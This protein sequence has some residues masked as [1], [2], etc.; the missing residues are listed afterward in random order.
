[1]MTLDGMKDDRPRFGPFHCERE[2]ERERRA[3]DRQLG[4]YI[5]G[6]DARGDWFNNNSGDGRVARPT[7]GE[8]M[9]GMKSS[10]GVAFESIAKPLASEAKDVQSNRSTSRWSDYVLGVAG[11]S[12]L[13]SFGDSLIRPP[14]LS[15]LPLCCCHNT[16]PP[17]H[18]SLA[19]SLSMRLLS[20]ITGIRRAPSAER[21]ALQRYT[22]IDSDGQRSNG[23]EGKRD[24]WS[25]R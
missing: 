17:F 6:Q 22:E 20:F 23:R 7:K 14:P 10:D 5:I 18:I 9:K 4:G 19:P 16:T 11:F 8:G 21:A 15:F 12:S 1:M 24:S 2:R 3:P 13:L 25:R